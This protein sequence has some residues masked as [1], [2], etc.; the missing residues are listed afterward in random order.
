MKIKTNEL[1]GA[2][3]DWAVAKIDEPDAINYSRMRTFKRPTIGSCNYPD[4]DSYW[5]YKPSESWAQG[6][7]IIE[8][9]QISI[10][11]ALNEWQACSI[12]SSRFRYGPTPL[13]TAMRCL[14][15]SKLGDEV[16]IP[17]ELMHRD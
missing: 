15:A 10:V 13:V 17:D 16:E 2:A 3:L 6:G 12:N 9:E 14:V 7:P 4:P 8:K 11:S 1:V 5:P